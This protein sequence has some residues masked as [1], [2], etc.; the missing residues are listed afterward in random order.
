IPDMKKLYLLV[1]LVSLAACQTTRSP[2]G[3]TPSMPSSQDSHVATVVRAVPDLGSDCSAGEV[4]F[5][6]NGGK[7]SYPIVDGSFS[8]AV[9]YASADEGGGAGFFACPGTDNSF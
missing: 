4:E 3:T 7:V 2:L 6:Q 9:D 8:G 5:Y 1:L